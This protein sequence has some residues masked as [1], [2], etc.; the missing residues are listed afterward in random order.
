MIASSFVFDIIGGSGRSGKSRVQFDL[1]DIMPEGAELEK[2]GRSVYEQ[3][4][5]D[6]VVWFCR[7]RRDSNSTIVCPC[8]N[9]HRCAGSQ[10]DRTGLGAVG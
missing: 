8:S 7:G 5:V 2:R 1:V 3:V 9:I 6:S 10:T 4:G